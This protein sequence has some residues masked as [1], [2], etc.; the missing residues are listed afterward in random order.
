MASLG[1]ALLHRTAKKDQI[2]EEIHLIKTI[3]KNYLQDTP[4]QQKLILKAKTHV[5]VGHQNE[6]KECPWNYF[7]LACYSNL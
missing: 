3:V 7:G 1:F 6:T 5:I 4:M 2:F